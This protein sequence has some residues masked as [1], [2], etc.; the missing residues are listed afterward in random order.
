MTSVDSTRSGRPPPIHPGE[1]LSEEFLLPMG[2]SQDRLSKSIGI[3]ARRIDAIVC[4]ERAITAETALLLSRYFGNSARL[5]MGLQTQH[6]LGVAQ[7]RLGDRL[8]AI[9]PFD[10]E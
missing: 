6:D 1:I 3:D 9:D 2:V 7:D 10:P 5:W 4:G 8:A